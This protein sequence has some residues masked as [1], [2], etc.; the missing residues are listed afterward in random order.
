MQFFCYGPR[1]K[2]VDLPPLE[3][4]IHRVLREAR[5]IFKRGGM[6]AELILARLLE[7]YA[8]TLGSA[9]VLLNVIAALHRMRGLDIVEQNAMHPERWRLK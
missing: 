1:P 9:P 6:P 7:S 8:D 5:G 3:A 2:H 4:N